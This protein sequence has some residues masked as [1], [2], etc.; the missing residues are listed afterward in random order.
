MT[1]PHLEFVQT[2]TLP[3]QAAGADHVRPGTQVKTLSEDGD[4]GARTELLRYPAGWRLDRPH[5][6]ACDEEFYVLAGSL[7]VGSVTYGEGDYG[8]LPAGMPRPDMHSAAG[9]SVLT[10]FESRPR[11]VLGDEPGEAYDPARLIARVASRTM[12]WSAPG[13]PVVAAAA[14]DCGRKL[15]REDPATGERTWILKMGPD[16]PRT[17]TAMRTEI[18]PVVEETFVLDGE[19]S[20]TCGVLKRGAYFWRPPGIEHGPVGTRAGMVAFFRCKGGP[21]STVWSD[22]AYPIQWEAPY[23]PVLPA[24]IRE[25]ARKPYDP[26]LAF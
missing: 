14:N 3:W 1:R 24:A 9:A 18:H 26:A 17:F 19:I 20:M 11:N 8:Y 13:D 6:L 16:D 7:A 5:H 10:F 15:L 12:P 2:Q 25:L 4:S 21:L 23:N 22:K